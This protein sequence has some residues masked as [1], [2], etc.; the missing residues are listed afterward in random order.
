MGFSQ[1]TFLDISKAFDR[2]WH[3]GLL[4]KLES[5]GVDDQLLTWFESYLSNRKHRG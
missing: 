1:V 5:L 4:V 2:V 3:R